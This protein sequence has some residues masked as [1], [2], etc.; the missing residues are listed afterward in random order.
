[1]ICGRKELK[2]LVNIAGQLDSVK[3]V[4][5]VDDDV[6]SDV[7]SAQHGW[8]ITSFSDVERLGRE[9][10]VEADLPLSADVAVIMYTS[11]STGLP[12][13]RS[14]FEICSYSSGSFSF[15]PFTGLTFQ[16]S[17]LESGWE[18]DIFFFFAV[19]F[20]SFYCFLNLFSFAQ[21]VMM[22]HGNILATV[23]AVVKI[24]PE[25][26]TKDVYL[27]YLPM[28]HILELIAEVCVSSNTSAYMALCLH[29]IFLC[30]PIL[31]VLTKSTTCFRICLLLLEAV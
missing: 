13:V 26:G 6:P 28:A 17:S 7:A 15:Y 21:G 10:P 20:S 27:A 9:N 23:S 24:V 5:C 19:L 18:C 12:K 14:I 1:M 4:I 8:T 31:H 25:L 11:G 3:H 16:N 22:T 29:F 2:S 30:F